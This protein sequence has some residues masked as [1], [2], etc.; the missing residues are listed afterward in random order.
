[1]STHKIHEPEERKIMNRFVL[2]HHADR[3]T[4]VVIWRHVENVRKSVSVKQGEMCAWKRAAVIWE[5]YH[6]GFKRKSQKA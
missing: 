4:M 1:M 6:V 5:L 3:S 2:D